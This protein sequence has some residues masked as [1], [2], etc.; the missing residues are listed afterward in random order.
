MTDY[1]SDLDAVFK[2]ACENLINAL[3]LLDEDEEVGIAFDKGEQTSELLSLT[4][5]CIRHALDDS[6][7]VGRRAETKADGL[8]VEAVLHKTWGTK[9]DLKLASEAYV[10]RISFAIQGKTDYY[11]TVSGEMY[12]RVLEQFKAGPEK[13]IEFSVNDT[14]YLIKAGHVTYITGAPTGDTPHTNAQDKELHHA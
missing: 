9:Q 7:L 4:E 8:T 13:F 12:K 11:I 10:M 14:H 3:S 5:S 2:T 6:E 1:K